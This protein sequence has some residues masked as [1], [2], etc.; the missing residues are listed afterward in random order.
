MQWI[1]IFLS[2]FLFIKT[3]VAAET[4]ETVGKSQEEKESEVID[5]STIK[6]VLQEDQLIQERKKK[7]EI[8]SSIQQARM[9]ENISKFNIPTKEDFWSFVSEYW[10]VKNAQRLQWDFQKPD[11]GI[12]PAFQGLLEKLGYY[13]KTYKI[14]VINSPNIQHMALP[15]NN[16]EY[17]FLI[18]L[19]FMRTLDLSK[20]EISLLL[21]E[22]FFRSE[23][24]LFKSKIE[25]DSSVLGTNF[26]GK[27][28]SLD[29]L[30]K[31]LKNYTD[32]I[33]EKGFSF[34][35]QYKV[36]KRM[37]DVLKSDPALWSAYFKLLSKINGL[38]KVNLLYKQ[39]IKIYPSPELQL[40]WLSPKKEVL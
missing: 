25:F 26:H 22:S 39:Y 34:A 10:L 5:Y 24:E 18:S 4:V 8:V 20:V 33:Y 2:F 35:E 15:G 21:L 1:A 23:L 29:W 13:N 38:V 32:I 12:G 14:M 28:L 30:N 36:T 37:D 31:I 16:D 3:I 27:E 7:E 40:K 6:D 17:I 9:K 19:P 11:Y